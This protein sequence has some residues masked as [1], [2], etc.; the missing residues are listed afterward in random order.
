MGRWVVVHRLGSGLSR[1][2]FRSRLV[3]YSL[4]GSRLGWRGWK[5]VAVVSLLLMILWLIC[6]AYF[7]MHVSLAI[8]FDMHL[9]SVLLGFYA[10]LGVF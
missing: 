5:Q 1:G 8:C 7:N 10:L 9:Y 6:R 2:R 4:A 3:G